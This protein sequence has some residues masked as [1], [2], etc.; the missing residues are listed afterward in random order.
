MQANLL[1]QGRKVR[2]PLGQRV[3]DAE[4]DRAEQR[5]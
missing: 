3:E 4:F 5:L 2:G 1:L